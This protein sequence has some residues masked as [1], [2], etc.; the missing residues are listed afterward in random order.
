MRPTLL[1]IQ[2]F[3]SGTANGNAIFEAAHGQEDWATLVGFIPECKSL[4]A[5]GKTFGCLRTVNT[6]SLIQANDAFYAKTGRQYGVP[7]IDGPGGLV[8]DLPSKLYAKGHFSR[9]PFIA[10]T[11][12]DEGKI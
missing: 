1:G 9:I 10:G 6:S 8:P 12:L 2:I 7:V 4:L 3:E 11:N 5:S